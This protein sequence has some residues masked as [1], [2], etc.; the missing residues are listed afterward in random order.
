MKRI[1]LVVLLAVV[2]AL[3]DEA[4]REAKAVRLL[5]LMDGRKMNDQMMASMRQMMQSQAQQK[6]GAPPP[7]LASAMFDLME[8]RM[9]WDDIKPK[10]AALYAGT[11]TEDELDG[12]IGFY[13]SAPG[14]AMLAKMPALMQKSMAIGMEQMK[15]ISGDMQRLMEQYKKDHPEK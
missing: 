3:A 15:D 5:D 13:E 4:S 7:E 14:K 11:Y 10:Y 1:L 2:P 8:K 9:K 6:G 12:I